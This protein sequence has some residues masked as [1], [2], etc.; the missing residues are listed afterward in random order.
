ME[1][2]KIAV[3]EDQHHQSLTITSLPTTKTMSTK[4]KATNYLFAKQARR[5]GS[6]VIL[7]SLFPAS[8]AFPHPVT[9]PSIL[10]MREHT[11]LQMSWPQRKNMC[12]GDVTVTGVGME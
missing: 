10:S 4:T 8:R 7:A 11:Y 9:L 2:A 6:G 5:L 3:L 1:F 12:A